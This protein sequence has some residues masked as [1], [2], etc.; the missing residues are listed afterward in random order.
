MDWQQ[1]WQ[2]VK[3]KQ[4]LHLYPLT[5]YMQ[6]VAGCVIQLST[7]YLAQSPGIPQGLMAVCQRGRKPEHSH[8]AGTGIIIYYN[9]S[10]QFRKQNGCFWYSKRTL[11]FSCS[12]M[13]S[14]LLHIV[15]PFHFLA[16]CFFCVC[17]RCV[18]N[19]QAVGNQ[20]AFLKLL[21]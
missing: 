8:M 14:A 10:P 11:Q 9:L 20:N 15:Q 13:C 19:H 4:S 18:T 17:L 12:D 3:S 2:N 21:I 1:Q 7:L 5:H 6:C 16:V